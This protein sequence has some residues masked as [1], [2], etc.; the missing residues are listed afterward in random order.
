MIRPRTTVLD[1]IRAWLSALS[2]EENGA[3]ATEYAFM[4]A[5]LSLGVIGAVGLQGIA[6]RDIWT[7]VGNAISKVP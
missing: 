2:T 1:R 5:V 6:N 4:L 7:F 3:T